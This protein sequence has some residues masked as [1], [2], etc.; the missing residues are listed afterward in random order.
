MTFDVIVAPKPFTPRVE[1]MAV[2]EGLTV[3]QILHRACQQGLLDPQDLPRTEVY[4]DGLRIADRRLALSVV[5]AAGELVNIVV[6]P[7]G[8]GSGHGK[9]PLEVALQIA[10][11]VGAFLITGP[12]GPLATTLANAGITGVEA[13]AISIAAAGAINIAG[14]FALSA[15]FKNNSNDDNTQY[16]SLDSQSNQARLRKSMPLCLGQRRWSFDVAATAFSTIDGND[17]YLTVMYG[18]HYGPC[19]I[20]DIKI[21][22]TLL[23]AYPTT[24]YQIEYFL[25]PGPRVSQLYPSQVDQQ[26]FQNVLDPLTATWTPE[27]SGL[28][29][30]TLSLDLYWPQLYYTSSGGVEEN[31]D[32]VVYMEYS[33]Y[34]ANNWLP[35][36]GYPA[37]TDADGNAYPAG[38][39]YIKG[40]THNPTRRTVTWTVPE[41]QYDVRLGRR[42]RRGGDTSRSVDDVYWTA[43]RSLNSSKPAIADNNLALIVLKVLG[44]QDFDGTL[45]VV[46]GVVTPIAPIYDA[47]TETWLGDPTTYDAVNWQPTSNAAALARYVMTGYPATLP[48]SA[49]E[50]DASFGTQYALIETMNWH[51]GLLQADDTSQSDLLVALG[52][53]GRCYFFWN[54]QA[55][56]CVPD[57][58]KPAPRQMFTGRNASNYKYKRVFPDPIHAVFVDFTNADEDYKED[59]IYVY[60]DGYSAANASLFETLTLDYACT[61]DR[62]QREGR[63]YLAKR[64][65]YV[66]THEWTAGIDAVASTFGDRVVVRHVSTLFGIG[67]AR[68]RFRRF[69]GALVAGVRMDSEVTFEAGQVYAADVRRAD[70]VLRS[71]PLTT[72]A[73][74]T[75]DLI[76][77]TPLVVAEAPEKGDL[78]VIGL[79]TSVTE[80]V[81]L[82]DVQPQPD[83]SVQLMAMKYAGDEIVAAET[84][85]IAPLQSQLTA[86]IAAPVPTILGANGD[87]NGVTVAFDVIAQRQ[88]TISGFTARYRRSPS[89]D[90]S[91]TWNTLDSL[92]PSSRSVT[93]PPIVNAQVKP[94][95]TDEPFS[96]DVEIRTILT[97]GEVSQ[98]GQALNIVV[99]KGIYAPTNFAALGVVRTASDGSSYPAIQI[100]CDAVSAGATQDL[101]LELQ[102]AGSNPTAWRASASGPFHG[103]NPNG[104]LTDVLGGASYDVRARWRSSDNW[105]SDYVILSAISVPTGAMVS[106][107]TASVPATATFGDGVTS[108]SLVLSKIAAAAAS[109]TLLFG[110]V[111]TANAAITSLTNTYGDTASAAASA[112]AAQ[113]AQTA[114]QGFSVTAQTASSAAQSTLLTAQQTV[115]SALPSGMTLPSVWSPTQ[116]FSGSPFAT[117]DSHFVTASDG[118]PVFRSDASSTDTIVGVGV[119]TPVVGRTYKVTVTARFHAAPAAGPGSYLVA[120]I[121]G[122]VSS[123]SSA[124]SVAST[125]GS[126]NTGTAVGSTITNSATFTYSGSPALSS[127]KAYTNV[128]ASAGGGGAYSTGVYDVI[129][130]IFADVTDSTA[131]A[132]SAISSS[133]FA[134]AANGSATAAQGSATSAQ[135]YAN[136]AS[137]QATA[138]QGYATTAQGAASTAT[139]QASA[140]ALSASIAASTGVGSLNASPTFADYASA[141]GVPN[142][143]T[144]QAGGAAGSRVAGTAS[145]YAYRLPSTAGTAAY[146]ASAT[147]INAP[148]GWYVLEGDIVLTAGSLVGS[149]I[150][151]ANSEAKS[152]VFATDTSLGNTAYG[153]GTVG[154]TYRF[155]TLVQT[156]VSETK[157]LYLCT[158]YP[159]LGSIATATT[160]TWSRCDVRPATQGEIQG[161]QAY[162]TANSVSASFSAFQT[163]QTSTNT[164]TASS[165]TALNA[166]VFT[167]ASGSLQSQ[168]TNNQ[169]A[170]ASAQATFASQISTLQSRTTVGQNLVVDGGLT[171]NGASW[172]TPPSAAYVQ[173]GYPGRLGYKGTTA[174]G[175]TMITAPFAVSASTTYTATAN[176]QASV[177]SGSGSAQ[178]LLIATFFNS[179]GANLN[180][181]ISGQQSAF[182]LSGTGPNTTFTF[183]TPSTAATMQLIVYTVING[184]AVVTQY[185]SRLKCEPGGVYTGWNDDASQLT[186]TAS[187][188]TTVQTVAT[189]S[190]QLYGSYTLMA[191]A[192]SVV[193]GVQ[194]LS[195][196]GAVQI[197]SVIFQAENLLI[198]SASASAAVAPFAYNST[199]GTLTL[200]NVVVSTLSALSANLGTVTAGYIQSP[201]G[202]NYYDINN[203]R[204]VF[205]NGTIMKV[206][207]VGFGANSDLMEWTGP[208][209]AISSCTKGNSTISY[210]GTDG[211]GY[212]GGAFAAGQKTAAA[213]N[214]TVSASASISNTAFPY[215]GRGMQVIVGFS[216]TG[217]TTYA[218]AAGTASTTTGSNSASV[219]LYRSING[220]ANVVVGTYNFSGSWTKLTPDPGDG[221]Y[222]HSNC[223][224]STSVTDTANV[225][226]GE[227]LV[228]TATVTA[229]SISTCTNQAQSVSV[230]VNEP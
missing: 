71:V 74:P 104:D 25:T 171:G 219:T 21:G 114:A 166:A 8:G 127:I 1:R 113:A 140:A 32:S 4:I 89:Q 172:S 163:T 191:T 48:L 50:I 136:T 209:M 177:N 183:T 42:I 11:M 38:S 30:T 23:S 27:T 138:A 128:N 192:G 135:G 44:C 194:Y 199:T 97:T 75:R 67:E 225:A 204:I 14:D 119:I 18:C 70:Q 175:S 78:I 165:I 185:V 47:Q 179:S 228:Y 187:V 159:G 116:S 224:G 122:L 31:Q 6:L 188:I 19:M 151:F 125:R 66:E 73:G 230:S 98:P 178:C 196:S 182:V 121:L 100:T 222:L 68:V 110:Q 34:G 41:G 226:N 180:T 63:V 115:A 61:L 60:N 109:V 3:G 154:N 7:Q 15:L 76:F 90:A 162:I 106:A 20:D 216:Y 146:I 77:A 201:S 218:P 39:F 93:T 59:G 173:P 103:D 158:A 65:L 207:G 139:A 161:G 24:D 212:F 45:G 186:L 157:Y 54:G 167:G 149:G 203:G 217:V 169:A 176:I 129:S 94:G 36:P 2:E 112:T 99:Q 117:T 164:A 84:A 108:A 86:R 181:N 184:T 51:G 198:K 134:T 105:Y 147:A 22:E 5:P 26:S 16:Y 170:N 49:A 131:S 213:Q 40:N 126:D 35:V 137:G 87:P 206:T 221:G 55:L 195:A 142:N 83:G 9:N 95:G 29:A 143:W 148:A 205:N 111:D 12:G 118:T 227:S 96:L 13:S 107:S 208:S 120:G 64:L 223:G 10:V 88:V 56:C 132:N 153:G 210:T 81:E 144:N 190:G 101:V 193:T 62:A 82:M 28:S 141:T 123:S 130:I 202:N 155:R 37:G 215:T 46:S 229:Y 124:T 102:P 156:T 72:S 200:Q 133:G 168:I 152:C 43:L 174:T 69:S 211:S 17:V 53:L 189:L 80:D 58:E 197:S 220:G 160:I 145:P 85:A 92:G 33:V 52:K 57:Y 150:V 91:A 214:P 79:T